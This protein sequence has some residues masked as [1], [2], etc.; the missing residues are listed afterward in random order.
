MVQPPQRALND[1]IDE[2]KRMRVHPDHQRR[3]YGRV[4]LSRLEEHALHRR[5]HTLVL[6][7]AP[8]QVGTRAL[9]ASTGYTEVSRSQRNGFDLIFTAKRLI[10]SEVD[11]GTGTRIVVRVARTCIAGLFNMIAR[12]LHRRTPLGFS[13]SPCQLPRTARRWLSSS[14]QEVI[15]LLDALRA[16]WPAGWRPDL[17]TVGLLMAGFFGVSSVAFAQVAGT[18]LVQAVNG[19][20][21]GA[22]VTTGQLFQLPTTIRVS[23]GA[24][25]VAGVAVGVT[26]VAGLALMARRRWGTQ[27]AIAGLSIAAL[28]LLIN[29]VATAAQAGGRTVISPAVAVAGMIALTLVV[30]G[31]L[32]RTR[33]PSASAE[34]RSWME[35]QQA[36]ADDTTQT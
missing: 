7:T 26:A 21:A 32:P 35:D 6:E 5:L 31:R 30:L 10:Y 9:Y 28:A 4:L 13:G 11:L 15:P 3:G 20:P 14:T 22:P 36:S 1:G 16:V 12:T 24:A 25:F 17:P 27:L 8:M 2:I 29:L 23:S 19:A 33:L 18:E 34:A